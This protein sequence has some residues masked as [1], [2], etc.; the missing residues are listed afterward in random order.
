MKRSLARFITA[1]GTALAL[2]ACTPY[3]GAD[4]WTDA[5]EHLEFHDLG[6]YETYNNLHRIVDRYLLDHN[7]NDPDSY[8]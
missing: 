3:P 8:D 2:S 6:Y 4:P 5:K 1:C 7:P